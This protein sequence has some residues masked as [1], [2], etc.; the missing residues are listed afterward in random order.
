MVPVDRVCG[1]SYKKSCV[2]DAT[3]AS[4]A[5]QVFSVAP[6]GAENG[7]FR[8]IPRSALTASSM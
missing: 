6:G 2:S 4:L 3:L 8:L 5:P 7:E 1:I